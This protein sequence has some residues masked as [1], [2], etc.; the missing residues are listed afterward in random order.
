MA[1]V[2]C[3]SPVLS[4]ASFEDKQAPSCPRW[5]EL[6]AGRVRVRVCVCVQ[7]HIPAPP[8]ERLDGCRLVLETG[9][10]LL[11]PVHLGRGTTSSSLSLVAKEVH[12]YALLSI[13]STHIWHLLCA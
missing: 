9:L 12:A 1:V 2:R 6:L 3:L 5:A 13:Y 4:I 8:P 10:L 11:S 7:G